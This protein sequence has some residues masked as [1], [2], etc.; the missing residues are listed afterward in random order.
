MFWTIFV[1]PILPVGD[2]TLGTAYGITIAAIIL[3]ALLGVGWELLYH[4]LQQYRWEK[5]W[6][7]VLG[8]IVAIPEGLFAWWCLQNEIP[9]S[10]GE[11]QASTFLTMF[12]TLWILVWA[13]INGPLQI[14]FLRWRYRGGRFAGGWG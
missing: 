6:P 5:D 3:T 12:I 11:V 13:I 2:A 8:L 7:T 10:V 9:W 14:F 1:T 4:F